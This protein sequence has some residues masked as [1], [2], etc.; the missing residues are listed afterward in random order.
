MEKFTALETEIKTL[1]ESVK[2]VK[3]SLFSFTETVD[4]NSKRGY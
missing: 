1:F 2:Q 4:P 3:K